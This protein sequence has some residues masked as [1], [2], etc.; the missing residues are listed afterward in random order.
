MQE[1]RESHKMI[2]TRLAVLGAVA[3]LALAGVAHAAVG[4]VRAPVVA[5]PMQPDSA[6]VK[7]A[8]GKP[9]AAYPRGGQFVVVSDIASPPVRS[10]WPQAPSAGEPFYSNAAGKTSDAPLPGALWLFGGALLAFV[11]I[12]ARRRF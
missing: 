3:M 5:P 1:S 8:D 12:S 4:P 9:A 11:G 10:T 2:N 7:V 6:V